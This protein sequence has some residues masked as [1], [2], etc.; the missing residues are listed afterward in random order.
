MMTSPHMDAMKT[1][2]AIVESPNCPENFVK[3]EALAMI[4]RQIAATRSDTEA[5]AKMED[6]VCRRKMSP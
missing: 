4:K 2:P 6:G 1:K 5:L 3:P